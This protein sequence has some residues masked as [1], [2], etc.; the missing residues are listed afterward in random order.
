[1]NC[2]IKDVMKN[3]LIL[4][5]FIACVSFINQLA[6]ADTCP[7]ISDMSPNRPPPG[8]SF[9]VPAVISEETYFFVEAVHSL[10]GSFYYKHVICKYAC[11]I[12]MCAFAIISDKIY[13]LPNSKMPPWHHTSA[14]GSTLTCRPANHD[15]AICVFQ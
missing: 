9:L 11:P 14:L 13:E 15:P 2:A 10:N 4:L 7:P 1:M 8:W 12:K 3:G 6:V 5:C